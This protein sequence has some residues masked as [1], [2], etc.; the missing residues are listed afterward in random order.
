ME[1]KNKEG[2][3]S[4]D[5][6]ASSLIELQAHTLIQQIQKRTPEGRHSSLAWDKPKDGFHN[7]CKSFQE[8]RLKLHRRKLRALQPSRPFLMIGSRRWITTSLATWRRFHPSSA[9]MMPWCCHPI[10][11]L[12]LSRRCWIL[13]NI[14]ATSLRWTW[15]RRCMPS[16][17]PLSPS[18]TTTSCWKQLNTIVPWGDWQSQGQSHPVRPWFVGQPSAPATPQ[19]EPTKAE[20]KAKMFPKTAERSKPASKLQSRPES[21]AIPSSKND[22]DSEGDMEYRCSKRRR[23]RR[24][25]YS[26]IQPFLCTVVTR[27]V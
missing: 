13:T 27:P 6:G 22:E 7:S 11:G 14:K 15:R 2:K 9:C 25:F 4:S 16:I 18:L 19:R 8:R 17:R 24:G 3:E 23:I 10:S 5:G 21:S 12:R 1:P 26:C 20:V